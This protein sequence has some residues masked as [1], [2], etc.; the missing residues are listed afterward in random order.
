VAIGALAMLYKYFTAPRF[1]CHLLA[2]FLLGAAFELVYD[3]A[4]GR[5]KPLI[6]A[7]AAYLGF[8][9]FGLTITYVFRYEWWIREGWPKVQRYILETGSLAAACSALAVPLAD[10]LAR[11]VRA[12]GIPP[13]RLRRW[14]L[15]SLS[16]A[17]AGLWLFAAVSLARAL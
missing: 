8:A 11:R 1:V 7:A 17:T 16:A 6:G 9:A 2:I 15:G 14:A 12:R 10:W 4:K 13:I 3:L 5:L